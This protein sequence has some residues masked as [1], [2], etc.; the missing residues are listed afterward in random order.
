MAIDLTTRLSDGVRKAELY[1]ARYGRHALLREK[2]LMLQ[3]IQPPEYFS[4]VQA[5]KAID[6]AYGNPF[7]EILHAIRP[8]LEE[9][10]LRLDLE[11]STIDTM[12]RY[13]REFAEAARFDAHM[14]ELRTFS[15]SAARM[16]ESQRTI[17]DL[18]M[19]LQEPMA[20][21][22]EPMTP[23]HERVA[24]VMAGIHTFAEQ[25][26]V[27]R[28]TADSA[29]QAVLGY[30]TY[31][32][33]QLRKSLSDVEGVMQRRLAI[34]DLAGDMLETSQASWELL[35]T[36][37]VTGASE[38]TLPTIQPNICPELNRQ[39]AYLYKEPATDDPYLAYD[40]S[41][42]AGISVGG[43]EIIELVYNIN[44]CESNTSGDDLFKA[45][46]R[47][48]HTAVV[49]T[50]TV[51]RRAESF[52]DVVDGLYWLLYEGSG[53]AKRLCTKLSD[54]ELEVLWWVKKLRNAFRHDADRGSASDV[55]RKRRQ[56]G[57]I[58]SELIGKNW[59][60]G[61]ADWSAAQVAL[62]DSVA[63]L[64]RDVLERVSGDR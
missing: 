6:Q 60:R 41:P 5:Q 55:Q 19:A 24:D 37:A 7:K 34:T 49:L 40:R 31:A 2:Q 36:Q 21:T 12:E 58:Y 51:A 25:Q 22:I 9:L 50:S 33:R 35:G 1:E 20:A 59:P 42:S 47:S 11:Q 64:L 56:L 17:R 48:L 46:N 45:T 28:A 32:E 4:A 54:K 63:R 52:A 23:P 44:E 15:S 30:Q 43:A 8:D 57:E 27:Y 10:R 3:A 16:M 13:R 26:E 18:G 38:A 14:R 61:P 53:E 29:M 39:L 62:Y